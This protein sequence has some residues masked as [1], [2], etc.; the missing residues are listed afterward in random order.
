[1]LKDNIPIR[2]L[3]Q[4]VE[5]LG[6][7]GGRTKDP[8]VLTELAR[9]ALVRTITE[10]H[11]DA[12][13]RIAAI[14]LDPALEYELRGALTGSGDSETLSLPPER[15]LALSQRIAEAW[16]GALDQGHDKAV[17]LCDHRVRPHLA[18]MLARQVPPLPVLAYDEIA[19]GT[20]I[21]SV[22]T[23]ALAAQGAEI[24]PAP[25]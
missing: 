16:R 15:V 14:V 24:V 4:I 21:E 1:L 22:G 25:G 10:Q 3:A 9:K 19:L 18:A 23:I 20:R 6:E 13:G 17:V 5:A 2:D 7:H 11:G 8:A 12:G